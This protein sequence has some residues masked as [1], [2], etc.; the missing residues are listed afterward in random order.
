MSQDANN[1]SLV[2]TGIGNNKLLTHTLTIVISVG[3][4]RTTIS[5]GGTAVSLISVY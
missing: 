1:S 4:Y 2:Q 3:R 5:S